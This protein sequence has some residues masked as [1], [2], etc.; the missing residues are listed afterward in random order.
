MTL[1]I[2]TIICTSI[3]NT[4]NAAEVDSVMGLNLVLKTH[5]EGVAPDI[6]LYIADYL[7]DIGIDVTVV[8]EEWSV[9]MGSV[10]Y[11]YDFDLAV[12]NLVGGGE[13]PDYRNAYTE[14]GWLNIFGLK[15]EIPYCDLSEQMQEEGLEITDL[16]ERQQH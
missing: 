5:G 7:E 6:A 14:D 3:V 11:N 9:F 10:F 16:E 8:I 4:Q 13:T 12:V 1:F 15:D 2:F